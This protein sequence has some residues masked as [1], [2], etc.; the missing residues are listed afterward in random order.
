MKKSRKILLAVLGLGLLGGIVDGSIRYSQQGIVTVQSGKVTRQDLVS[1]VTASGEIKPRNYINVGAQYLGLLTEIYVKEGD[2]VKKGQLLAKQETIQPSADVDAQKAA[3]QTAQADLLA[4]DAGIRSAEENLRT[5]R[6]AL[7]RAKADREK[8]DLD[9]K[10]AQQL[11]EEKLIAKSEFDLRKSGY[12]A[13]AASVAEAEARISQTQAMREQAVAQRESTRR[14][15][16]QLQA[17]LTRAS[18]ILQKHYALAPLDGIVTNLPVRPGETVV[19]GIQNS[20]ASLIMTIA[21]MSLITA[22]VKVDETDIVNVKMGQVG[23]INIDAI[24]NK[25]FKGHVIE[26]GN[27]AIVRSTG[28]AASQTTTSSQ[29]AK[30]FKV[31]VA[32]D[33]PPDDVRPGLSCTAKITTATRQH[34]LTIPIQALTI[35][36]K[37]DLDSKPKN[38]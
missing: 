12:D 27:T 9:F 13:A 15:I 4:A 37:G 8:A 25:T 32:L 19:P 33:N 36:Q 20:P 34:T 6:A 26:I 16:D 30:D 10:R 7:E 22:E 1:Q 35:R 14:R 38:G 29:E 21:D 3:L 24:P 2:R 18:D 28:L 11:F 17:V 23:D 31:V 5:V